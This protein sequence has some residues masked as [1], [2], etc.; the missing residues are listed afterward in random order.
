MNKNEKKSFEN[1]DNITILEIG[2]DSVHF[3]NYLNR[4]SNYN[5]KINY[6]T[7]SEVSLKSK[8]DFENIIVPHFGINPFAWRNTY[9]QLTKIIK[10][11]KPEIIHA[12]QVNRLAFICS[13][14]AKKF[15]IPFVLTAWGSDV[16][17]VPK[18]SFF[19]KLIVSKT[20]KNA[21][22]ITA[23][24][25]SMIDAMLEMEPDKQKYELAQYGIEPIESLPK[26][27]IIYS[28][29]LLKPNY[30][31]DAVINYFSEFQKKHPEYELWIAATGEKE[32]ELKKLA[33]SICA[34]DS[35]KFLGW[36]DP[37]ENR[38]IYAQ[39][40]IYISIPESDGTS[41]SL[42]EAMSADCTCIVSDIAVSK[43][44]IQDG[45]NGVV[46][47]EKLN[48]LEEALK[49]DIEKVRTTN[50]NIIKDRATV[51]V[52]YEI[53]KLIYILTLQNE[54]K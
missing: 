21:F 42:L 14:V 1:L 22:K 5:S 33:E 45:E 11:K 28:N 20:L 9:Q 16:L 15:K 26:Q 54:G 4:I 8:L 23:D 37:A 12:H 41:V 39:A 34:T 40:E 27:K 3:I 29:R 53:F 48:P 6:L 44:W 52:N 46:E 35:Y 13:L 51:D 32:D 30:R 49:I 17:L 2:S 7:I 25:Q 47:K 31:I 38:A 50:Q 18:V 19:H 43:E 10:E 24:S 36:Q